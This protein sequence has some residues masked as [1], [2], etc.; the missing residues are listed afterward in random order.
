MKPLRV[1]LVDD[2]PLFRRGAAQ[3]LASSD[4]LNL[5]GQAE[6]GAEGIAMVKTAAPE[7][8]FMDISMPETDGL[9]ATECIKSLLPP[10]YVCLVTLHDGLAY[11][12]AA[13][14]AGAD[15]LVPKEAFFQCVQ[16]LGLS[17]RHS[18]A[19]SVSGRTHALAAF[20]NDLGALCLG[21]WKR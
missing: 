3:V 9:K 10:P 18:D 14:K 19:Q 8:V 13:T 12:A 16:Q 4:A 2:S 20:S 5:V 1:L 6:S 21:E 7:F 11:R 15:G 17:L